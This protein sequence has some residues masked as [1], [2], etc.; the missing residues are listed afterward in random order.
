MSNGSNDWGVAYSRITW[1]EDALR[2]HHN[3]ASFTRCDDIII[4]VK[5]KAGRDITIVC[6]DEY[7]LGES[8][9]RRIMQ[10]FPQVNFIYVGGNWNGYTPEA[11]ELCLAR[12]VGLYNSGELTGALYRDDF[13]NYHKRDDEGNPTYPYK[14]DPSR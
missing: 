5:R 2:S 6:L 8:G 9:I 3:V 11:K 12:R 4:S 13:W 14:N 1:L 7:A 10:E